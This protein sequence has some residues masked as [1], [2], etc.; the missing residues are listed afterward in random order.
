MLALLRERDLAPVP[1]QQSFSHQGINRWVQGF[2]PL[3]IV[4]SHMGL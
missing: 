3:I 1:F 4:A 2:F